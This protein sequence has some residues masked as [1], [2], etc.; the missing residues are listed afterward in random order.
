M[1]FL[2]NLYI[3]LVLRLVFSLGSPTDIDFPKFT[4]AGMSRINPAKVMTSEMILL[5]LLP[6]KRGSIPK[7][8]ARKKRQ[9]IKSENLPAIRIGRGIGLL[10]RG[11]IFPSFYIKD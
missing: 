1:G 7:F 2:V 5:T 8:P 6:R 11:S 3:P 9:Q 10:P 4:K